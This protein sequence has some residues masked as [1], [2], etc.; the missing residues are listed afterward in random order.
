VPQTD[1]P[2]AHDATERDRVWHTLSTEET[3]EALD[4]SARGLTPDEAARRLER[5]GPN[6]VEAEERA[7]WWTLLLHQV[8]DPLI[9]ILIV[10]AVVALFIGEYID[11][12][13]IAVV[14]VVNGIIGFV[15]EMKASRAMEA[16]ARMSAP[17][18]LVVRDGEER[19][20][21]A[22][23]LVPGDVVR[24][25]SGTRVPADLRLL[26]V[27][28]LEVDESALT[29]ESLP[30]SKTVDALAE[31]SL[32]SGDQANLAFSGTTV[33]RGRARGLVIRT[34]ERSELG[35]IAGE[36]RRVG[37]MKTPIQEKVGRLAKWIGVG[38]LALTAI[39]AV[40]GFLRGM[41][42]EEILMTAVALAVAAIPEALPIIL[43]ITLA[44]G[45][46][47]MAVRNTIIRHLPAVETLGSTTVIASDKTGTL[48]RNEMTVRAAW[49]GDHE[50]GVTGTGYM[51][52]GELEL[53]GHRVDVDDH[54][55]L[56]MALLAGVLAS[57]RGELPDPEDPA[58]DPTELAVLVAAAKG[59]IDPHTARERHPEVDML[60]FESERRMMAT[61]NRT[62]AGARI[63][64]KGAPEAVL[65]RCD[66]MLDGKGEEASLDSEAVHEAARELAA[67]GYRVLA[68][69][70][71]D[72]EGERVGEEEI[73]GGLVLAGLLGME[74]PLRDEARIAVRAARDAG[75]RVIMVTGDHASTAA[76][77]GRQLGMEVGPEGAVEGRRLH[78]MS[79]AEV[80]DAVGRTDVFARVA[81]EH[82]LRIVEAL[83]RRDEIVAVTGDGVNDAPAL[84]S[85]HLGVAMGRSGTDVAREASDMVLTDDNFASITAAVEEGRRVFSN[86]RK[87][88][89]FLLSGSASIV[90]AILLA[91][92]AGWPLPFL[93]AQVLWINLVTNGLQDVALAFEPAEPG[94]LKERPRPV[95]EAVIHPPMLVRIL[96]TGGFRAAATLA[97]FWWMM[98]VT[99]G[100]L[101]VAQSVAMT[102]IVVFQFFHVYNCR[103]LHRSVFSI[104]I[105]G[106]KFLFTAVTLAM[107]AQ[108]A[109]LYVPALQFIFRTTPLTAEQ[110]MIVWSVG[111]LIVLVA[112]IDKVFIR[113][114]GGLTRKEGSLRGRTARA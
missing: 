76:A 35:R 28:E 57:E 43:T 5:Y 27:R 79:D 90:L 32:V 112:E 83:R 30:A 7:R 26:Q 63:Y 106:N 82:K 87:V 15:Q 89:Y 72:A 53:D 33:T 96:V 95:R 109:I 69:A 17:R 12:G 113:K 50:F 6:R 110:W 51:A 36:M 41:G 45:V 25:E 68:T 46:Q 99:G 98:E 21:P 78:E 77:I 42:T 114:Y 86:I 94:L 19:E 16:L 55:A 54:P 88:T 37:Q 18:A 102:Q 62:E 103:S 70:Y 52:E 2:P 24:L 92:F 74:D 39:A 105:L 1:N 23:E 56:G 75:I 3:Q 22:E 4:A 47:R 67:R 66:R 13:V 31:E 49:A 48:T 108:L 64:V 58:G 84:R 80:D 38:V 60:P 44:V 8:R 104:P 14:V 71:R 81:P 85:A 91:L 11:A 97:V 101:M 100:D 65:D 93:A 10:A 20:I 29:G 59:G 111:A 73:A 34:G 40:V 61:L 9:Y 107:I